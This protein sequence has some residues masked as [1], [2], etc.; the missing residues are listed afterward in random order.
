[1]KE[2]IEAYLKE[3]YKCLPPV[4]MSK[5]N[6][7]VNDDGEQ[8]YETIY[9]NYSTYDTVVTNSELLEFMWSRIK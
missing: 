9:K 4:Q 7:W 3:T 1:M 8:C 6:K 5:V 2:L